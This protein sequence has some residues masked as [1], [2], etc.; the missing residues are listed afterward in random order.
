MPVTSRRP[1]PARVRTRRTAPR[2]DG[3][4]EGYMRV[5]REDH[6]GLSRVL[7]E[8]EVQA[9]ALGHAPDAARAVLGEAMRY[10]L[11]YQHSVHHPREDQLFE[12]IRARQPSLFENM[13]RLVFEH[14]IG[15]SRAES[16]ARDL[17]RATP[18]MLRGRPGVRLAKQLGDYVRHTR[19]HMRREELVFYSG[20]ER[21]LSASD[22]AEL[23]RGPAPR[24]PAGD[25]HRLQSRY[26]RLAA[27]LA[28]PERQ[29]SGPSGAGAA[30]QDHLRLAIERVAEACGTAWRETAD[31]ARDGIA[32]L[33]GVRSPVGLAKVSVSLTTRGA[34]HA[35][36]LAW[37]PFRR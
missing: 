24:D 8:I 4:A 12:R 16:L 3:V 36:R 1:A 6:A 33:A 15:Q 18:A 20:A 14:R 21:V 22:W 19:A 17:R 29:V 31:L 30:A 37:L 23:A 27:R 5:L 28:A 7:R 26:P 13:R 34:R 35:A 2:G 9:A 10:L 32:D 25:L 11:V